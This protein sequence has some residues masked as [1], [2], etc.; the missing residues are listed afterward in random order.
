L[1]VSAKRVPWSDAEK[2]AVRSELGDFI[3]KMKVPGKLECDWCLKKKTELSRRSWKDVK[4]FIHNSIQT[5]RKKYQ[6]KG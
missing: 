1:K 3:T 5:V 2:K 4:N 6:F